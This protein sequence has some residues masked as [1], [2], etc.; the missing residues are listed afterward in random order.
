ML[1]TTM[2]VFKTIAKNLCVY[3]QQIY[4]AHFSKQFLVHIK[5]QLAFTRTS[6]YTPSQ[7]EY[8]YKKLKPP[9]NPEP[10]MDKEPPYSPK[11][12]TNQHHLPYPYDTSPDHQLIHFILPR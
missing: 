11:Y 7:H 9:T 5:K 1:I 8:L 10:D 4:S 3:N 6:Q 12:S 2:L